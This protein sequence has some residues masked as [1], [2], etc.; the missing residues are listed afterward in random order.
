MGSHNSFA[1]CHAIASHSRSSSV[2]SHTF[3]EFFAKLFNSDTTFFFSGF[4]WYNGLK[5]CAISTHFQ[6]LGN[7]TICPKEAFT[8]KSDHKILVMVLDFAG[9]ST[10][11]RFFAIFLD[12]YVN[13]IYYFALYKCEKKMQ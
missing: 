5:S 8:S 12:K 11:T 6:F 2:A 9:D 13:F 3:S 1:T 4:N 7:S 10:I